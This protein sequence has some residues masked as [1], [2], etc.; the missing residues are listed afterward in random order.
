M[1]TN[2]LLF[3][4]LI[5]PFT[6]S[7]QSFMTFGEV[8]DFSVGDKF[9]FT[10]SADNTPNPPNAQRI[11]ITG[12][13]FSPNGDTVFYIEYHNDYSTWIDWEHGDSL[14]YDFYTTTDTVF[15][16]QLDT[17]V[18]AAASDILP[19][20]NVHMFDTIQY[21]SEQYCDSLV[22]G[23]SYAIGWFE[24]VYCSVLYGKGLGTVSY[25]YHYPSEFYGFETHLFYYEKNGVGCGTN[26]ITSSVPAKR[27]SDVRIYPNPAHHYF[28]VENNG[29][30]ILKM[31]VYNSNG[32]LVGSQN[33][34]A[35]RIVYQCSSFRSG[36]YFIRFIT[37][38]EIFIKKLIIK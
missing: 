38:S 22:N 26:D 15:Y 13:Y 18:L 33:I 5:L 24:P 27:L 3:F 32:K 16:T 17:S 1:K 9:Q 21:I 36:I 8:Y 37:R 14:R 11:T 2:L 23:Y 6:A 12:K 34:N 28:I 35:H 4:I 19:D 31:N 29:D 25:S 10:S 30:K 20:T 7:A